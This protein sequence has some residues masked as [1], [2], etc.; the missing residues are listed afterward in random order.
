M[1]VMNMILFNQ[2]DKN[3]LMVYAKRY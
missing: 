3:F 1:N 2:L